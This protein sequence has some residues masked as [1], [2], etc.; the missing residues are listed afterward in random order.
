[1]KSLL[2]NSKVLLFENIVPPYF[3]AVLFL[4]LL[5]FIFTE[6]QLSIK[7]AP[8]FLA[9]LSLMFEFVRLRFPYITY[10]APPSY[11]ELWFVKLQLST[12]KFEFRLQIAPP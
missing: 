6:E 9:L 4:K 1:M 11:L 2:S 5:F 7:R 10:M 8:P 3:D 12:L